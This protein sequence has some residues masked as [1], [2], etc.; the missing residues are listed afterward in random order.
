MKEIVFLNK[1][2]GRWKEFEKFLF[3]NINTDPDQLADL[4]IQLTDDLAYA[5]TFYPGS[6]TTA[7]LNT[8]ASK[9]HQAIYR[10]KKIKK[11]RF[12]HFW[13][14]EY[15]LLF[16]KNRKYFGYALIIFL[17]A[18]MVGI[19]STLYDDTYVRLILGDSYVNMTLENIR[20][21]DPMAVYKQAGHF[22]MFLGISLNNLFVA[23]QA[24]VY[25]V[26]LSVITGLVLFHNGIMIGAFE[27][28]FY[29]HG[30]LYDSFLTI[31]IHGTLEIFSILVAGAA[32][33]RMGNSILFPGTYTRLVS[34]RKGVNDGLKMVAGVVPVFLTAAFLEGFVTR[35]TQLPDIVR[36]F[37]IILSLTFIIY[38]FFIYPN[39]LKNKNQTTD[40]RT[41]H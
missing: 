32:G 27:T 18:T 22:N 3:S 34:F 26:F 15:P 2:A 9:A 11:G 8:L 38:Y 23:F 31:W 29:Q 19:I 36:L 35:Y 14:E 20:A 41:L 30:L 12:A 33:L 5:R 4:F 21:G 10:N 28:F 13:K 40:G 37:I 39:T 16:L 7:Y 1:N 25:G 6:K 17:I 24:F